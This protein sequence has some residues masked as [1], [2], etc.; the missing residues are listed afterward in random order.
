VLRIGITPEECERRVR[1]RME[2]NVLIL[3]IVWNAGAPRENTNIP[4]C[5]RNMSTTK[6]MIRQILF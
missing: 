5:A 2:Y 6:V 3:L 1:R 4:E